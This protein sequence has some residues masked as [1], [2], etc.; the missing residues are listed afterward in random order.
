MRHLSDTPDVRLLD[1]APFLFSHSLTD[2]PALSL[3]SL[4]RT[5]PELPARCLNH[6]K[7]LDSLAINFDRSFEEHRNGL[8][9]MQSFER[10]KEVSSYITV[11]DPFEHPAFRDLYRELKADVEQ[12]QQKA[13]RAPRVYEGRMWIFIASPNAITPF[14]FDRYSNFLMQIRG[15]KQMAVFPN[16]REDIVP[17]RASESYMDREPS[18]DL[19]RDDLDVHAFKYDFRP[20]AALH[21]PFAGGHYVKNGAEDI[22]V[23]LSFFFQTEETT[24]WVKAS[25]FNNRVHRHLGVQ[26]SPIGKSRL[27]DGLKASTLTALTAT[28]ATLRRLRSPAP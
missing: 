2:H 8:S 15:S 7:G 4:A 9:L 21:I 20:G 14:H 27:R 12:L 5:I 25:Q 11:M 24:R 1:R 26:L 3:E 6:S 10:L 16:F 22:S 28:T 19:W 13:G 17:A 23:S 18:K